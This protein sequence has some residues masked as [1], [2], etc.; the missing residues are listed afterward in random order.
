MRKKTKDKGMV[1]EAHLVSTL[2]QA[3]NAF[4]VVIEDGKMRIE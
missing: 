2:L 4:T 1:L 3:G